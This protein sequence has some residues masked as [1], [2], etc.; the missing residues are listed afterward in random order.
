MPVSIRSLFVILIISSLIFIFSKNKLLP[1]ISSQNFIK[2]RNTWLAL[3]TVAFLSFNAYIYAF[4]A[5]VYLYISKKKELALLL[6]FS[7]LFAIP[8]IPINLPGFGLINYLLTLDHIRILNIT[9]LLPLA[10]KHG[11]NLRLGKCRADIFLIAF[12]ILKG[13]LI[14]GGV[15]TTDW[16]RGLL[17]LYIDVFIP[18]YVISR[19]VKNIEQFKSLLT[20][21]LI[22]ILV[23]GSLG[24]FE[25]VWSWLLYT[26][27]GSAWNINWIWGQY[28]SRDGGLRALVSFGHSLYFGSIIAIGI[29][30]FLYLQTYLNDKFFIKVT[31]L[32]IITALIASLS[33][34][35]WVSA[36]LLYL[37][38]LFSGKKSLPK[39]FK[40]GAIITS[41]LIVLSPTKMGDKVINLIPFVGQTERGN[42]EYRQQLVDVSLKVIQQNLLFGSDYLKNPEMEVMRQGQ[43][44]I[45][46]V[47]AY[48]E[49]ALSSGL[50][51]LFLFVG[52]FICGIL[53]VYK[54]L[55]RAKKLSDE[56]HLLG[57]CI[58]AILF[59]NMFT[60]G[61]SGNALGLATINWCFAGLAVA[62][63]NTVG[64]ETKRILSK[65]N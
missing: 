15:T 34:G 5:F 18:Y 49:V 65:G 39:L 53:L 36:V 19:N 26:P 24:I 13:M 52:F 46:V 42:I 44:I 62:Y 63:W 9:L 7:I 64:I 41:I 58:L 55:G 40:F 61:S 59:S 10:F 12:L 22:A 35:P 14:H 3:T 50:I 21:L 60:I 57:R 8:Q 27:L 28:L 23:A 11:S 17:Y 56:Y 29:G 43:G 51:G 6:Y 38:F 30:I 47:N 2:V 37:I 33:R 54:A 31:W 20:G 45:D 32:I 16:L 4:F 25:G 1:L 48:I